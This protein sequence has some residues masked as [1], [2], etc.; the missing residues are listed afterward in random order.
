MRILTA[1]LKKDFQILMRYKLNL[2][3]TLFSIFFYLLAIFFLSETYE[4]KGVASGEENEISLFL[5]FLT[6]LL[7]LDLTLTCSSTLPLTI[8]FY[9]TSGIMEELIS[10][11]KIFLLTIISSISLPLLITLT[12]FIIYLM[13]ANYLSNQSILI[14]SKLLVLIPYLSIYLFFIIGIGL[15]A[16]S[17][18]ILFKR[19]NPI[20][21][22]NNIL[23][24]SLTGAFIPV[25]QLG[26]VVDSISFFIPGKHYLDILRAVMGQSEFSSQSIIWSSLWLFFLSLSIFFIGFIIFKHAIKYAKLNTN[27]SDY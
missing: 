7:M 8:N 12:K 26:W 11:F 24:L 15:A 2:L 19:G 14:S 21:T 1:V 22:L 16:G 25:S 18:T 3:T 23:T 17:L 13:L 20:I 6:G 27:T 5:F 9:Q 4:I 10:D